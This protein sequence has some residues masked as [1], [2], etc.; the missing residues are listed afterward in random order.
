MFVR[1]QLLT[2][3]TAALLSAAPVWAD[4][5]VAPG[6]VVIT[7]AIGDVVGEPVPPDPISGAFDLQSVSIA[8]PAADSIEAQ[9]IVFTIKTG[10][11]PL[12][13]GTPGSG[14]FVSFEDP[15]KLVRGVRADANA[16]GGIDFLSYV[17]AEDS[18][19]EFLGQFIQ[20]GS[21]VPADGSYAA[22]GTLT[23]TVNAKSIGIRDT[24]DVISG[25]NGGGIAY[26]GMPGLGGSLNL[27]SMPDDLGRGAATPIVYSP[28]AKS[29]SKQG[30]GLLAGSMPLA[31]LLLMGLLALARRRF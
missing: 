20:D 22:D 4:V 11:E 29:L 5:C 21:Q 15:R 17:A 16:M 7:D 12:T 25:F 8:T 3:G 18:D 14:I 9:T 1:K 6:D 19:G 30:S 10:G 26:V 13:F 2:L 31:G 28:C 23:I 24:G 27:D